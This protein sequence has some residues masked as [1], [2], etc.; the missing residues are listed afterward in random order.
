MCGSLYIE[1]ATAEAKERIVSG[2][3]ACE[4][5]GEHIKKKTER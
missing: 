1:P 4:E 3:M 5:A 2:E